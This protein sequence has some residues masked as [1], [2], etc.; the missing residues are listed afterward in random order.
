[1]PH[2]NFVHLHLHSQYSLL[3]GAIRPEALIALAKEYRMPAVAVTDH[4]ALFGAIDF[5]Q[6]AMAKGI[7][8]I[9]G[10]EMYVAT[11]SRTD[12]SPVS[13]GE[14]SHHLVLL[15][16]NIQ[17]YRNLCKLLS[18][19][20]IE[21]FY[22]KPRV[23]KDLLRELNEG[24]IALSAC[25]HGEVAH[26]VS[27]GQMD[28]AL[29]AAAEYKEIFD[30]RRF[31]L[32]IQHNGMEEQEKV[33][34]GV[35]EV[36][37][38]LDIPLVATNDCH[39]LRKE[40]SKVHDILLCIQTGTTV[41]APNR[42][43]FSTDEFYF[44]SPDEMKEAFKDT[45]E[46]L[47]NTIEIAERCNLELKLG[48]NHL[49]EYAVPEGQTLDGI[50]EEKAK[51]GLERRL[52]AMAAKGVDVEAI[53]WHYFERLSKE[54]KVIKGMGFPGYFLIV[55]DFIDYARSKNIPVGPGRGSAAGSLVA[56]SLGITNLDPIKYNLL[57]ERFLNPDRISLPDID[58]DFCFEKR[59]EVIKYVTE[60]YGKDNVTQIITF[61]QMKA[62]A[63]IR[64]VGRALDMP[65]GDVDRIAKLVPTT[66]NIT[67]E[68]ALVQEPKLKKMTEEDPKVK[69]LIEVAIA[70]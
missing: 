23:D 65:Y 45:P 58:I 21:G 27:M 7:K 36:G 33:N 31:Y 46:A 57:F 32:E 20:Y 61:G 69:E 51:A 59:D 50:I 4:G 1:M 17:G 34:R 25:L 28:A 29:K 9:I 15:V 16:K 10:C 43:R 2:S 6:K 11:G 24:L 35:I 64:D 39:Y 53:R 8:P 55:T 5:Y 52:A 12:K 18:L 26:A 41:N 54:L 62:K 30:N 67:I 44:K 49:P 56:Y 37:K 22:Y 13:R 63:C 66:L 38:K 70:L 47:A 68:E 60:R 48:E 19:A 3:D 40:D 42:M 14:S